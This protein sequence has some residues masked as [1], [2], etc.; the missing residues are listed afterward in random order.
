[1][2]IP[3]SPPRMDTFDQILGLWTKKH[4][5]KSL[6]QHPNNSKQWCSL[7][8]FLSLLLF[9]RA[10]GMFVVGCLVSGVGCLVGWWLA[11]RQVG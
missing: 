5:G 9:R 10:A 11:G 3:S 1:M 7:L 4:V 8:V 6:R 2:N